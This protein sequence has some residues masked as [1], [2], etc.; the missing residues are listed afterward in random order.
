VVSA[1]LWPGWRFERMTA[2]E[3]LR[4]ARS[5]LEEHAFDTAQRHLN[6]VAPDAPMALALKRRLAAA[7]QEARRIAAEVQQETA[8]AELARQVR[9]EARRVAVRDLEQNL[10]NMGFDV[11]V[12]QS[13]NP[14]EITIA[15]R[16]FDDPDRRGWFLN[17]LHG[18]NSPVAATCAA[19][20]QTVRLKGP[21]AFFGFS[22]PLSLDCYMR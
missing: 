12:A 20:I 22:E 21:G 2:T 14:S 1:A 11:T 6:A 17:F 7:R 13:I 15:S 3:H 4:A 16:G 19:G 18:P 5:A 10:R 8:A 9:A